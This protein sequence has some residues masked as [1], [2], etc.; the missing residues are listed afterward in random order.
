MRVSA[1]AKAAR[2]YCSGQLGSQASDGDVAEGKL[3]RE[4]IEH[5]LLTPA[6]MD[7]IRADI[8]RLLDE[9]R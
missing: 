7:A 5:G 8:A 6:E 1:L 4:H 2:S 9:I 3:L